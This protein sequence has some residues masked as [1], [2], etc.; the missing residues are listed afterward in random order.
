M[1][2]RSAF[3]Q[4]QTRA[5]RDQAKAGA[6]PRYIARAG[7]RANGK[8]VVWDCQGGWICSDH[9]SLALAAIRAALLNVEATKRGVA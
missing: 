4:S 9:K 7:L 2:V 1:A 3:R 5:L 8:V 6:I